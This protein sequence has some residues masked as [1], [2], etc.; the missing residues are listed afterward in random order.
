MQQ[1]KLV[2][3][4]ANL[5]TPTALLAVMLTIGIISMVMFSIEPPQWFIIIWSM[6]VGYFFKATQVEAQLQVNP[7]NVKGLK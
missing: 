1:N 3:A 7:D 5:L 2:N 4:A 6:S